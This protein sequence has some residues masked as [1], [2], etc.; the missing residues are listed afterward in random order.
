VRGDQEEGDEEGC[1]E[2]EVV[3]ATS[4]WGRHPPAALIVYL[5]RFG[6]VKT[7]IEYFFVLIFREVAR[8]T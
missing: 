5:Y 1:Q 4:R 7:I 8:G 3:S 6:F 2:E